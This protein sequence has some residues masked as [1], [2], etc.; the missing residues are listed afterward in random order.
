[1]IDAS[2]PMVLAFDT[3]NKEARHSAAN[4]KASTISITRQTVEQTTATLPPQQA[5]SI[6]WLHNQWVGS[7]LSLT[8]FAEQVGRDETTISRVF[9]G[10]YPSQLDRFVEA[11][12]IYR[13]LLKER[14]GYQLSEFQETEIAET[15]F[16]ICHR[17]LVMQTVSLIIGPS[18]LGKSMAL[19]KFAADRPNVA[20]VRIP[21]AAGM[22]LLLRRIAVALR[23][24][25]KEYTELRAKIV[26]KLGPNSLLILDEAHQIFLT[27]NKTARVEAL[28]LIREIWDETKCGLVLCGTPVLK[29]ELEEGRYRDMLEQ[30]RRRCVLPVR[31]PDH[32]N[33]PDVMK[34]CAGY[35]IRGSNA[36]A[37]N[38]AYK[39]AK[40]DGLTRLVGTLRLAKDI[41][42]AGKESVSWGNFLQADKLIEGYALLPTE[43]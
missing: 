24:N 39:I 12:E 42:K 34:I 8:Q 25:S 6:L 27:F 32:L 40:L 22:L 30:L 26:S 11:I 37:S 2:D 3:S 43:N 33:K 1:M 23:T 7:G 13:N 28:E 36:E 17:T 4:G 18:Q 19:Q 38:R 14:D 9:R 5:E 29:K 35:G 10:E 20:Y 21:A 16:A 15:I 31:L 41:A